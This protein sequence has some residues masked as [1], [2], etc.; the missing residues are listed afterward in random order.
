MPVDPDKH[1]VGKLARWHEGLI[2]PTGNRFPVCALF[3]ASGEHGRV[4]DIFRVYRS[5][6]EELGS[7]F[8]D[9]VIFG[10]HGVSTSSAAIV[11]GLGLNDLPIPS[12]TL[13]TRGNPLVCH[14]TVL[15]EEDALPD[16]K[17]EQESDDVPWMRALNVIRGA[18][19]GASSLSLGSVQGLE[20][21]A[22]PDGA[23]PEL[24]GQ[25]RQQVEGA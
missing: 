19:T 15:P 21:R 6:F 10:Q 13:I 7:E 11:P 18:V 17:V 3:L 23:L 22:F 14:T 12:L 9:L 2:S 16:G 5:A 8:H 24:V 1:D 25:V 20:S 4:H